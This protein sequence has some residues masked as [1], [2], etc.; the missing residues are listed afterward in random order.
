MILLSGIDDLVSLRHIDRIKKDMRAVFPMIDF[1]LSGLQPSEDT[2]LFCDVIG[3]ADIA[4]Y[5]D[6]SQVSNHLENFTEAVDS[7]YGAVFVAGRIVC[8]TNN[9]WSLHSDELAILSVYV[10][11]EPSV[12]MSDTPIFLPIKSP[13]VPFR[14]VICRLTSI[15]QVAV[16]C[17]PLPSLPEIQTSIGTHWSSISNILQTSQALIPRCIPPSLNI[18]TSI[19]G[20]VLVNCQ[21]KRLLACMCPQ[22]SDLQRESRGV[23]ISRRIEVLRSFYRSVVGSILPASS[24][25]NPHTAEIAGSLVPDHPSHA[26]LIHQASETFV[27][28]ELHKCYALKTGPYQFFGMFLPTVPN[29]SVREISKRTLQILLKEKHNNLIKS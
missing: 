21:K 4:I 5:P 12:T 22:I 26:S 2:A 25:P 10:Y 24:E 15:V 11:T 6:Q 17:G 13:T 23:P 28:S 16:L 18:D 27:S 7:T 3:G 9:W 14:L 1:L 20:F 19:L 8:A 29:H